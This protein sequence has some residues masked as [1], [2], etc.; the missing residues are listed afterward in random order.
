[1]TQFQAAGKK[2]EAETAAPA[3]GHVKLQKDRTIWKNHKQD[4]SNM[5]L[6]PA[7]S[8]ILAL[9]A[10]EAGSGPQIADRQ[11]LKNLVEQLKGT[12][13]L[14]LDPARGVLDRWSR[15]IG[16]PALDKAQPDDAE[17]SKVIS[18]DAGGG[19]QTYDTET[20]IGNKPMADTAALKLFRIS[21]VRVPYKI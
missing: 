15:I 14:D 18:P 7:V 10:Q 9:V 2:P 4:I 19:R 1:M 11:R 17:P 16:P 13:E 12:M 8:R 5:Y 21:C 6:R 20:G 3:V